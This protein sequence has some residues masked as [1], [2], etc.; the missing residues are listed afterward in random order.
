MDICHICLE[1]EKKKSPK[2]CCAGFICN[3]CWNNLRDNKI[4]V[5]PICRSPLE[6]INNL[7]H[8]LD[9]PINHS[10]VLS[11]ATYCFYTEDTFKNCTNRLRNI[12]EIIF[13][14]F[15]FMSTIVIL[16]TNMKYWINNIISYWFCICCIIVGKILDNVKERA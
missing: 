11:E 7:S 3:V 2:K 6:I 14:G 5:C 12:I 8:T 1:N 4:L 10:E 15:I 13:Y 16:Y 9:I